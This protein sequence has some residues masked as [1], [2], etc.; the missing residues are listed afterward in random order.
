MRNNKMGTVL[1]QAQVNTIAP[2]TNSG[3]TH[4]PAHAQSSYTA[5]PGFQSLVELVFVVRHR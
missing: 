2:A 4:K 3:G 1:I 5:I